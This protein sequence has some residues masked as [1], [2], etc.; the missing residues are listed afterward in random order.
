LGDDA[1]LH[2]AAGF[3]SVGGGGLRGEMGEKGEEGEKAREETK[4]DEQKG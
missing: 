2:F 4:W 3:V 1:A